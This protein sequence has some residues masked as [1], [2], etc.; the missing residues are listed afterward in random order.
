[1]TFVK[2]ISLALLF[3]SFNFVFAQTKPIESLIQNI[4]NQDAY[5][6]MTRTM[7]PRISSASAKEIVKIGKPATPDLIQVLDSQSKGI[8]AHFILSEIWKETWE[9]TLCCLIHDEGNAEIVNINGLEIRIENEVL[10]ASDE[11]LKNNKERWKKRT[12][13]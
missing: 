4:N 1:M 9:E 10:S 3:L 8:A 7:S 2:K 13:A 12:H 6:V 11:A 5:I